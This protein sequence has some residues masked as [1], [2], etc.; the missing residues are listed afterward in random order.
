MSLSHSVKVPFQLHMTQ[1]GKSNRAKCIFGKHRLHTHE[2][3]MSP[4][5]TPPLFYFL[6][7]RTGG[8]QRTLSA[9]DECLMCGWICSDVGSS[10]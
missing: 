5:L 10:S 8:K 4:S 3:K 7:E 2:M 1:F 6:L 9:G